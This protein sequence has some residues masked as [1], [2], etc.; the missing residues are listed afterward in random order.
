M[1]R[2]SG[3]T[4]I[5]VLIAVIILAIVLPGLTAFVVGSRKAL[6]TS[7]RLE[8]GT[9]VAQTVLDSLAFLPHGVVGTTGNTTRTLEGTNYTVLWSTSPMTV[10][11]NTAGSLI[12]LTAQ[13]TVGNQVRQS[14]LKGVLK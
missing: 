3:Y 12:T 14:V 7:S 6:T 2:R 8:Q 1:R 13:W 9:A 11:G 4:I 5:E 10:S